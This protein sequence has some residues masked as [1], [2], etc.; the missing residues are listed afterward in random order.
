MNPLRETVLRLRNLPP[1]AAEQVL[2]NVPLADLL[3]LFSSVPSLTQYCQDPKFWAARV[4]AKY[5][6]S[7]KTFQ[8]T[9][10]DNVITTPTDGLVVYLWLIRD[11]LTSV[12]VKRRGKNSPPNPNVATATEE[13][14]SLVQGISER[15]TE[16][17]RTKINQPVQYYTV[18]PGNEFSEKE[19]VKMFG[20][21]GEIII[22]A[23]SL[24]EAIL[25]INKHSILSGRKSIISM[26]LQELL[27]GFFE[28]PDYENCHENLLDILTSRFVEFLGEG[29]GYISLNEKQMMPRSFSQTQ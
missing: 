18:T 23:S 24:E 15:L 5:P 7:I 19:M 26:N 4:N 27:G 3:D 12:P 20:N 2:I 25:S 13:F 17:A 29:N 6:G 28:D 1:E 10:N 22:P 21:L 11:I 14:E 16:Q 8:E 9:L